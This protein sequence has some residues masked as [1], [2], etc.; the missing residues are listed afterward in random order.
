MLPRGVEGAT[1]A[2]LPKLAGHVYRGQG[3]GRLASC[4]WQCQ[5]LGRTSRDSIDRKRSICDA[6]CAW[7]TGG[8]CPPNPSI[9]RRGGQRWRSPARYRRDAVPRTAPSRWRQLY[10]ISPSGRSADPPP[11]PSLRLEG[12]RRRR[13]N[14]GGP[15]P[16]DQSKHAAAVDK[17]RTTQARRGPWRPTR[18]WA[19]GPST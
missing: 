18:S 5:E 2:A 3:C 16:R 7:A 10:A 14:A 6:G 12:V 8:T 17:Q 19:R 1:S 4:T 13:R 15:S 9:M 11:T